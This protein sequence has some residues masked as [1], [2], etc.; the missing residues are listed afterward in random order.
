MSGQEYPYQ[1]MFSIEKEDWGS[2]RLS[3]ESILDVRFV[4]ADLVITSEDLL[5][6]QAMMNHTVFGS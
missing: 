6:A 2:V 4:L 5:G 1:A 3:G